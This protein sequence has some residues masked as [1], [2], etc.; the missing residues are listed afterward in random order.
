[1]AAVD[2]INIGYMLLVMVQLILEDDV[3]GMDDTGNVSK[4]TEE[5]V[6]E[7]VSGASSLHENSNGGEEDS[8]VSLG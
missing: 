1:M 7:Q 3:E 5:D 2:K 6:D 8:W 4:T